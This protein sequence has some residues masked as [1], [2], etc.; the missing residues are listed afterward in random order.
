MNDDAVYIDKS[1]VGINILTQSI[2]NCNMKIKKEP[3]Q[4]FKSWKFGTINIRSG[5]EKEEGAKIYA[6]TKEM[7][8][9]GLLF[10]CM[11]EVRY[12]NVG[13]KLIELDTGE[14]YEFH[15]CGQKRR[16]EEGVGILIKVQQS[17]E[18]CPPDVNDPR[19][20][21]INLK[22]H[23]FNI[24]IVNGYSP[25]DC[26]G[27]DNQK[28]DFYRSMKAACAT[29]QKHQKLIVVGDLNA[30]THVATYKSCYDSTSIQDDPD[31]NDNGRRPKSFC[32]SEKLSMSSTF[33]NLPMVNRYT[34]Y[35]NDKKTK[36][37][38]DYVLV[39][40]FVQKY[41][42]DCRAEPEYD[43]D[44]DHR[45]LTTSLCT[46]CTRRSRR[47][48]KSPPKK[49]EPDIT[50][51]HN[52]TMRNFYV[53]V[54]DKNLAS[55]KNQDAPSANEMSR[56]IIE[57]I[58]TAAAKALPTKKKM[59]SDK[60]LWRDDVELNSLLEERKNVTIGS[61][62][63][64]AITKKIK[65]R[66]NR[67]RNEKLQGEADEIND[68]ANKR[69]VEEPYRSM[70]SDNST[71]KN[72]RHKSGCDPQELK[73]YFAKHF[74]QE[75]KVSEPIE[76]REPMDVIKK[77]Q[78]IK[79]DGIKTTA[80]DFNEVYGVLIK[81]KNGKAANDIPAGYLMN[82]YDFMRLYG[83]RVKYPNSGRTPN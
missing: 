13:N 53:E 58:N 56:N 61:Q 69:Q 36:R 45:L 43:F 54:I 79:V 18:I 25:T 22:I 57:I 49:A 4:P 27:S 29:K 8:R 81:L 39:E 68:F 11:Q 66:V 35:S 16:R 34:W 71:F 44:S 82:W 23:G 65:K 83:K 28:D 62:L 47:T 46:P 33:F 76:L 78:Q 42:I 37:I 19:I 17:I 73:K 75:I 6:V 74:N 77:L 10:C 2:E 20:M 38:N 7:N 80:P 60:Q 51:L 30:K 26:G 24:R 72:T 31:C 9:A 48:P 52:E 21:A 63:H 67:L 32:R 70:K 55:I 15:W 3:V 64:K 1:N 14:S 40:K 41:V 50:A 5:K 12:R 59:S